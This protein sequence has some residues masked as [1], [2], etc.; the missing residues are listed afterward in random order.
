MSAFIV[1]VMDYSF[2][3]AKPS[4]VPRFVNHCTTRD[5]NNHN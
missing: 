2:D 5:N 1:I 4:S 3:R